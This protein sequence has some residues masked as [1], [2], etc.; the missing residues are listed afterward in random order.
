VVRLP[1]GRYDAWIQASLGPGVKVWIRPV[2]SPAAGQIGYAANDMGLP[3]LWQPIVEVK[4]PHETVVHVAWAGRAWW[5]ASSR[6]PNVIG[7]LVFT[8]AGDLGRVVDVPPARASSLCGQ[9]LDWVEL[10]KPR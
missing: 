4:L 10:G 7:P 3:A 1:A 9:R 2:G 5:K 8:R 6:H